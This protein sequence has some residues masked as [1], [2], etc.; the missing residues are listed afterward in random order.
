[1]I[2]GLIAGGWLRLTSSP[3]TKVGWFLLAGG[4]GIA[5]GYVLHETGLA[6][7][8][9]RI[10][11]PSWVL[12]SGGWCFFLLAAFYAVIDAARFSSWSYPLRVIG[13]NS[14]LAYILAHGMD[15]FV[16]KSFRIHFGANV[17]QQLRLGRFQVLGPEY[18]HLLAGLAVLVVFW[19]FLWW[20]YR[21]KI[22][23]RI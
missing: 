1:M 13:A 6:P 22:F 7:S 14:I 4:I 3:W 17:F 19:L 9:K 21:Q 23:L 12:Y 11:T 5:A 2:L 16:A 15:A 20:L 8:V 18:E 10:W